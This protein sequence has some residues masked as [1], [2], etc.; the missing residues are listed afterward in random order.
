MVKIQK[1]KI[2]LFNPNKIFNKNKL[3][4]AIKDGKLDCLLDSQDT[5][6][7]QEKE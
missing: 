4:K 7:N 2:D 6:N 3:D 5:K 1:P